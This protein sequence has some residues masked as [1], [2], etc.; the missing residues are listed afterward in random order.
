MLLMTLLNLSMRIKGK[1]GTQRKVTQ[2]EVVLYMRAQVA[3]YVLCRIAW[4]K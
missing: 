4:G 1:R 3:G 2:A